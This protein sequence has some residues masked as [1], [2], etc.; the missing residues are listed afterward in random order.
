MPQLVIDIPDAAFE[1][2]KE[3]ARAEG[4]GSAEIFI[5]D[6]VVDAVRDD[7]DNYDHLFTPE[8]IAAIERGMRD[9]DEGNLMT[10]DEVNAFLACKKAEW[11]SNPKS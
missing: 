7:P 11:L 2:V 9:A 1:S 3:R 5:S 6:L 10:W 8:V 4:F